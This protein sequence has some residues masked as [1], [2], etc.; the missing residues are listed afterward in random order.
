MDP[1]P[2][3]QIFPV[4]LE[5][6]YGHAAN[7]KNEDTILCIGGIGFTTLLAYV[8]LYP[9]A[10]RAGTP[11]ANRFVLAWSYREREFEM[12]VKEMM[13]VDTRSLGMEC[14][15][16]LSSHRTLRGY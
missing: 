5:G 15:W 3:P 14:I 1:P 11:K 10:R 2:G 4:S 12:A 16:A 13:Q 7:L 9:E 6:P 8:P